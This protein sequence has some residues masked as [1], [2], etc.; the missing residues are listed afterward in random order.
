MFALDGYDIRRL[1]SDDAAIFQQLYER[2]SDYHELVEGAPTRPTPAKDDLAATP[3]GRL[4]DDK[5][6]IGIFDANTLVGVLDLFRDEPRPGEWWLGLLMLD[7]AVRSRGLGRRIVEAALP[8][9]GARVMWLGVLEA[10]PRAERF[11]RSAGF[12]EV[13][14]QDYRSDTGQPHRVILMRY[15]VAMTD[16]TSSIT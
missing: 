9:S 2:C 3:P 16:S 4:L 7:P 11:W 1:G 8:W 10:N 12:A 14:R 6:V 13:K 15:I 5:I